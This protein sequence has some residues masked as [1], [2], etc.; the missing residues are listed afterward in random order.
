MSSDTKAQLAID[1]E[2]SRRKFH[3]AHQALYAEERIERKA[4]VERCGAI[5]HA[6]KWHQVAG[7]GRYCILCGHTDYSLD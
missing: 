3:D 5:G 6:F 1:I 7:D 4:L 2:I